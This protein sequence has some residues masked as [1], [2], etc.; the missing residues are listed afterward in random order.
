MPL[1]FLAVTPG[2]VSKGEVKIV[3]VTRLIRILILAFVVLLGANICFSLLAD[4]A[5]TNAGGFRTLALA[6]AV[7][8]AAMGIVGTSIILRKSR[9]VMEKGQQAEDFARELLENSPMYL[10]LWDADGKVLDCNHKIL[11]ALSINSKVEFKKRF[12]DF[13]PEYQPCGTS[14]VKKVKEMMD[15]ATKEGSCCSEWVFTQIDGDEVPVEASLVPIR[16]QGETRFIC[17]SH[18]LRPVKTALKRELEV[19][20]RQRLLYDAIPLPATMWSEKYNVVDC[21]QAMVEFLKVPGKEVAIER[22]YEFSTVHQ[23]CGTHTLDKSMAVIDKVLTEGNVVRYTWTHLIDGEIVPVDITAAR[24]PMEDGYVVACYAMDLRPIKEVTEKMREAEERVKLLL[25]AAPMACYLLDSNHQA[26]DCNQAAVELFAKEPSRP[27]ADTY[28]DQKHFESCR[29]LDCKRCGHYG[30]DTCFARKYLVGRYR[31]TFPGYDEDQEQNESLGDTGKDLEKHRMHNLLVFGLVAARYNGALEAGV[32]QFEFPCVTLYGDTIPCEVTIVPVQYQ[33]GQGFAVYLRD[34]RESKKAVVEMRK[35][36]VAEKKSRAKSEF[37]AK[38]SHEIRTPMNAIIG[39]AELALRSDKVDMAHEHILTVKQAGTNLLSL[40]NDILDISKI[41]KGKLDIVPTEYSFSSLLN[42]VIRITR[43]RV[44]DSSLCFVVNIDSN[45][46]S[47]LYGDE[48]RIRQVLLNLLVNAVK[49]TNSGGFVSLCVRGEM[50]GEDTV[51]LTIDVEDSGLGIKK[52][53][54]E[55][56]FDEYT[57]FDQEANKGVE[58]TGLGLSIAWHLIDAMGGSINVQ[59]EY[60]KGST[61]TVTFPQT[62]CAAKPLISIENAKEKSVLVYEKR[63]LYASSL[64]FA[65]ENL[66]V[67]STL[68]FED[69]DFIEKLAGGEYTFAFISF[70]IYEKNIGAIMD[71]NTKTKVVILTEFGETIPEKSL[72]VLAMPVHSLSMANIINGEQDSFSYHGNSRLAVGFTAPEASVL[73]VDDILTN[74]KVVKGLMLPYGMQVTMCKSG[75]MA[76]EAI[77]ANR[78]DIVFMDHLMPG[79]DG[80][81]TTEHIRRLGVEDGYFAD[82]PIVALTANAVHGMHEFFLENGFSDFMSKP[83]DVVKLNS[84]LEK[85][86]P[87]EKQIKLSAQEAQ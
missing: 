58:G 51:N 34:L 37:L 74:L 66:G 82:V 42:D 21:N 16:Y 38:M 2:I 41:E 61:F 26:I 72:T 8:L 68:V 54:L 43:I 14:S 28:P 65:M 67:A 36:E 84:I 64:I 79:M 45:L 10:E 18:D 75:P 69:S 87:K 57:Q 25:D 76:I 6:S 59:S 39:M 24:V 62:V 73:A 1:V 60:G 46:P 13:T 12:F 19:I 17:Y 33:D 53:D 50:D 3:S 23:P 81:E 83:V 56:L 5:G 32:Q 85:W 11:D 4:R 77:K 48:I 47:L 40:I 63:D 49:Y 9:A 15:C 44:I 80:V 70:G 29:V 31:H 30:H 78:Y 86:I 27:L 20:S 35:R 55:H 22:F 7:F 71:L 52:E